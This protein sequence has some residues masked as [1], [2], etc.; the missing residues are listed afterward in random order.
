MALL[1]PKTSE[2]LAAMSDDRLQ[3]YFEKHASYHGGSPGYE[4]SIGSGPKVLWSDDTATLRNKFFRHVRREP[5]R[6][7]ES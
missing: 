4:Y 3:R 1:Q 2:Q 5:A 7:L 6:R